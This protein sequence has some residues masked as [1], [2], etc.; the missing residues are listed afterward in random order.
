MAISY[1]RLF[2]TLKKNQ[3]S[4]K[5]FHDMTGIGQATISKMQHGETITSDV[6]ERVCRAMDCQPNDI[7]EVISDKD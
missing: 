7:M 1:E 4:R 6:I 3:I 2:E 5:R